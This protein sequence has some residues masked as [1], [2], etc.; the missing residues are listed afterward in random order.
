M[1]LRDKVVVVTGAGSGMGRELVFELLRRQARVAAVDINETTLRETAAR[2]SDHAAALGTFTLSITDRAAVTALPTAVVER[3]GAV[4]AVINCAGIIQPFVGLAQL[5]DAAIERV[6]NVN[7][8]GTL[9]MTRAFL[10]VLLDRPEAHLVNVSSM[11]GFVPVP[12]QTIYGASKAAVKLLT[13]GLHSE[14]AHTRVR[15]TVVIPG[16]VATNIV[17]NSGVAPPPIGNEEQARS[18]ILAADKAARIILDAVERD[19]YR[20]LVGNDAR[21]LDVFYRL[22]PKRTAALIGRFMK[23]LINLGEQK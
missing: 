5:D 17:D 12:G 4:D 23:D 19:R 20:V 11:G 15:V 2:A 16:G 21:A 22:S 6:F 10:P 13:E 7:W 8:W 14:L 3:F 9:H 1:K 18:R